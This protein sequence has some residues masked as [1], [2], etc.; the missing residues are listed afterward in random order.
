MDCVVAV[1]EY[2]A[3]HWFEQDATEDATGT[4]TYPFI[5]RLFVYDVYGTDL[6]HAEQTAEPPVEYEPSKPAHR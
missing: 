1:H 5:S 4:Y 3:G 6:S 2:P